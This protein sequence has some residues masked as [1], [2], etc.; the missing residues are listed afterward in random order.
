MS[1]FP[2]VRVRTGGLAPFAPLFRGR[3][4]EDPMGGP[5]AAPRPL[6]R[7]GGRGHAIDQAPVH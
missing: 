4:L 2:L 6:N 5:H 7:G 3:R 1:V